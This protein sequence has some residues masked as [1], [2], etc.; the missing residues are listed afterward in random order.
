MI[1]PAAVGIGIAAG[2][3]SSEP[4]SLYMGP[5]PSDAATVRSDANPD[6]NYTDVSVS[7]P[8]VLLSDTR[9]AA[10]ASDV[11]LTGQDGA[12]SV[13]QS[14]DD[15]APAR[16][17]V[18]TLAD[19]TT[20]VLAPMDGKLDLGIPEAGMKYQGPIPPPDTG[21]IDTGS[22]VGPIIAKYL[23]PMQDA[24]NDLGLV[25]R[26]MAPIADSAAQS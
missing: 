25:V 22:E 10:L 16:D 4:R 18:D 23:A 19:A 7:G 3:C 11:P 6:A 1:M 15:Q 21:I 12:S 20:D 13:D 2:S 5:L 24:A 26:Y 9:E 17:G 14:V 8:E